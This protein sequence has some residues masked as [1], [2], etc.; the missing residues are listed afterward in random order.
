MIR[1]GPEGRRMQ[2]RMAIKTR[3]DTS[4]ATPPNAHPHHSAKAAKLRYL[5]D[6]KPGISRKRQGSRFSYVSS[7]G[8]TIRDAAT[9]KRI[10][11]LVIP[12]AWKDVW[13]S[14]DPLGH[15]QAAGR[16]EKGRKQ[17]RYHAKWH[18]VRDETKYQKMMAFVHALPRI[19]ARVKKDLARKHLPRE[20]V[21]ATVV[22]LLETTLIRV[23]NDEYA[24][25]NDSYG[26]TTLRDRHAT[27]AGSTIRFRFKGKSGIAHEIDLTDPHV[28]KIVRQCQDLPGAELLQYVD[29]K[30]KVRDIG[31]ADVNAYLREIS[32]EPFTAKDFRTWAGTV[33]AARAL[34]AFERVVS[35]SAM[36]KNI[37]NAIDSVA[38]QLGNTRAVCRKCYV[39]PEVLNA[40]LDGSLLKT[41]GQRAKAMDKRLSRLRPEEA[42]VLVL[43]QQ[44]LADDAKSR[45]KAAKRRAA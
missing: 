18:Q 37:V 10:Q 20:K 27:I 42:A 28:A 13:I 40:Y 29:E 1:D 11:A 22:R 3:A 24:N 33:L 15:L 43:L 25:S 45:P 21:L 9:L 35:E 14:P 8:R 26:L 34:Q 39:H 44:R 36:K 23:G 2:Q 5:S 30:G 19:R 6:D 12:P 31:S 16:D 38:K 7:Q 41:L 17:Y 4:H 32:G